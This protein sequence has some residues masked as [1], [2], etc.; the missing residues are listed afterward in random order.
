MNIFCDSLLDQRNSIKDDYILMENQLKSIKEQFHLYSSQYMR[1]D[2]SNQ[3]S[4]TI[5]QL[6]AFQKLIQMEIQERIFKIEGQGSH[7]KKIQTNGIREN[8]SLKKNEK[9]ASKSSGT[10]FNDLGLDLVE[11]II[12]RVWDGQIDKLSDILHGIPLPNI[13][14]EM[15][16]NLQKLIFQQVGYMNKQK[17]ISGE[18]FKKFCQSKT[19][20]EIAALNMIHTTP[21]PKLFANLSPVTVLNE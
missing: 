21:Y 12:L 11:E 15:S 18:A 19:T 3:I 10:N 7:I 4:K 6:E 16:L 1:R 20:L 9:V 14:N 8:S 17:I 2:D 13:R 5:K